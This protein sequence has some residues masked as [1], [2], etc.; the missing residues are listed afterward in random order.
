MADSEQQYQTHAISFKLQR[1]TLESTYVSVPVTQDV[2]IV[3]PDG[4]VKLDVDKLVTYAIEMGSKP[5]CGWEVESSD[6]QLHPIQ[7][8]QPGDD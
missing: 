1:T 5:E 2:V 6:V 7:M 3:Q 8:P 4:S